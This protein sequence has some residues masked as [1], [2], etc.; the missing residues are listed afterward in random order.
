MGK[1]GLLLLPLERCYLLNPGQTLDVGDRHLTCL[2]PPTFDAP[3]T[4]A[5]FDTR[6]RYLFSADSFGAL[7]QRP[8]ASAADVVPEQIRDGL[9]LWTSADSPWLARV[10]QNGLAHAVDSL[11]A[12]SPATILSSHLPPAH[13]MQGMLF[14]A[15]RAAG[16]AAPFVGP[17]QEALE[18]AMA[19]AEYR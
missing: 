19:G 4:T 15:L 5:L 6:T 7:L 1:M 3:E 8:V 12:F 10:D 14:E 18:Q 11:R 13:G 9:I 16:D 17:D 2:R